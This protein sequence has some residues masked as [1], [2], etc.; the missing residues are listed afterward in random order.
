ME[1]R[2]FQCF[3]THIIRFFPQ[4][5][6]KEQRVARHETGLEYTI[7]ERREFFSALRGASFRGHE[8][9][10]HSILESQV[11]WFYL[12]HFLLEEE[13]LILQEHMKPDQV[14]TFSQIHPEFVIVAVKGAG[15][16]RRCVFRFVCDSQGVLSL[17]V[18]T[19]SRL[20][21]SGTTSIFKA[22]MIRFC[23]EE[24][25]ILFLLFIK[26]KICVERMKPDHM[27][28]MK[29]N[30][31]GSWQCCRGGRRMSTQASP[32]MHHVALYQKQRGRGRERDRFCVPSTSLTQIWI[33]S[34][35]KYENHPG[36]YHPI[37]SVVFVLKKSDK[38]SH[39]GRMNFIRFR[40]W[41]L[42]G[43]WS[44]GME[45]HAV[46]SLVAGVCSGAAL[47]VTAW[48]INRHFHHFY[49]PRLQVYII[50]ILMMCP[51][52]LSPSLSFTLPV[53]LFVCLVVVVVSLL[54]LL[55]FSV[56]PVW[57]FL[58]CFRSLSVVCVLS[59]GGG[60]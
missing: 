23:L 17:S 5:L 58:A 44:E 38:T 40:P 4:R 41:F 18:R 19:C 11:I 21:S 16:A 9:G 49:H 14:N 25:L 29:V 13:R 54:C 35:H 27:S 51:V 60:V 42:C 2:S 20:Q 26:T 24:E 30:S 10:S 57:C 50:R 53:C 31:S 55:F 3:A 32:T 39:G 22:K 59:W 6:G 7:K 43:Y 28:I 8:T 48:H 47:V 56:P 1:T 12:I 15:S 45:P 37:E 52:S 46:A 33:T 34:C 36:L